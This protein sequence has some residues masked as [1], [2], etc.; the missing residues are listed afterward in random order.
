M[1]V[2]VYSVSGYIRPD[3]AAATRAVRCRE[4]KS[5]KVRQD[6]L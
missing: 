2:M 3:S 6:G 1:M 5:Y 4:K